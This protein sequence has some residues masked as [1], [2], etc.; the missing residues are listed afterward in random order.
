MNSTANMLVQQKLAKEMKIWS[1]LQHKNVLPLLGYV[2][3]DGKL[4]N[5]ISEWMVDGSLFEYLKFI[6]SGTESLFMAGLQSMKLLLRCAE[7][8]AQISG[9]ASGLRYLHENGVIH[10]DLKSVNF[11]I[12]SFHILPL[13]MFKPNVLISATKDPLLAD[14]GLSQ[15]LYPLFST[16]GQSN[17]SGS[18]KGTVRWMAPELLGDSDGS[19]SLN[20]NEKSDVWAFGMV[21]YVFFVSSFH[22]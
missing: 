20:S 3:E 22:I 11:I 15:V 19:L 12:S 9:I 21:V 17:S 4:P 14:F 18:P 5:L 6:S 16:V 13:T 7:A 8:I 10:A 2:I 1:T